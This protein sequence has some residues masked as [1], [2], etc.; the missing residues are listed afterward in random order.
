VENFIDYRGKTPKKTNYGIPL[1]TAKII[2]NGRLLEPNEFIAEEGYIDW[3]TRGF[4]EINDVVLTT[5][6]PLGEIALIKNNNV[7]LGQRIITLHTKKN[8]C[9]SIFLKYYLLS[10]DG[11]GALQ[12]RASGSTVEGIKAAELKLME[13]LLPSLSEQIRI[14]SILK[15][16]DDKIDLLHRQ[17]KTLEQL[18]ETL[19]RQWFIE[20][21]DSSEV[22]TLGEFAINVR[23]NAKVEDLK[24]YYKYVGLEHLPRKCIALSDWG[25]PTDLVSNKSIFIEND[26][27]FG[28]L[29]SYFHKVVFAPI[30]GVCST[31]I[32]VIRPKRKE[33]F[34]FCLFGF[35]NKELVDYSDLLSGGTRMPRTSWEII[36]GFQMQR[37]NYKK[38]EDFDKIVRPMTTKITFNICQIHMIEKLRDTLLPKLMNGEIKIKSI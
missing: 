8:L 34:S 31:D 14:A 36:S 1:I 22:A 28:K 16:L 37:P 18:A 17:N 3:M 26:I 15:S 12:S 35:F 5:E 7:A 25:I 38:L 19:F 30:R 10:N 23:E 33:W 2:K 24:N 9:N 29:R 20:K 11:Q 27:L 6:A 13:I 4:P 21:E 32:L